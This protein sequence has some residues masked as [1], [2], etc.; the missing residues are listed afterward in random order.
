MAK[1][2]LPSVRCPCCGHANDCD[3]RFCQQCGYSRKRVVSSNTKPFQFD[4][5]QIDSRL[6]QLQ[7]Y[8]QT[9][10]YMRQKNSLQQELEGFLLSLPARPT[11]ATVTPRD[12]C[13][14]LVFKDRHGKTQVHHQTCRF[15]G[16]RG[17]QACQCPLRLSFKTVDS[18][19]GK[20]RSVFHSI[21]RD[22]EWDQRLGL[23][24][25][26]A[27]KTIKDY[28]RSVTTE[29]LQ[30][31]V[32][33]KQATPFFLDKLTQLAQHLDQALASPTVTGL[34]KFIL[35][36][37]Q[38][39]FKAVFFSGDRPG[40]MGQVQV[41]GI[42]RFPND[43][44]FLFNHV[45]GKTLRDGDNNVFGIRRN[46]N[47]V[48]CP[49]AAIERYIEIARGLNIDLTTGYLFRPTTPNGGVANK[50]F[51]SSAAEARLKL[52]LQM[53]DADDGETLHGFRAGCAITLALSGAELSEIMDHVGWSRRHTALYYLKLAQ[54][55]RPDGASAKLAVDKE[56]Q[57]LMSWKEINELKRFVCAFPV[58]VSQKRPHDSS[59]PI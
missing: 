29:Q 23:G 17:V 12:L 5:T 50:P 34:Q 22:G 19:I 7:N 10:S 16:Q 26:A 55:L 15:L 57:E 9:T 1:L 58:P 31:R 20:L 27:D 37:D 45:W 49:V 43:D 52:Y 40:D 11:L 18:Y 28:L 44:G 47:V 24:N 30:A 25:P 21:G 33:P 54:V 8:A 38:A 35:A 48:V 56:P 42:L 59:Q 2:F 4:I 3:F 36:R 41:P 53:M 46:P 39:Y 51:S 13:R 14:F 6:Q 32:T